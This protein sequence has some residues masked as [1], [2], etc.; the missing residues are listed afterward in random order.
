MKKAEPR[1][2]IEK[3]A[4]VHAI[5]L[6]PGNITVRTVVNCGYFD[7][8]L[9]LGLIYDIKLLARESG[10]ATPRRMSRQSPKRIWLIRERGGHDAQRASPVEL[11]KFDYRTD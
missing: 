4:D 8:D 6:R 3:I 11:I 1:K 7:A 2:I 9:M 10:I 5:N